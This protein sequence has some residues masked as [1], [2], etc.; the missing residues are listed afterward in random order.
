[1]QLFVR[2]CPSVAGPELNSMKLYIGLIK[3]K[4][5]LKYDKIGLIPFSLSGLRTYLN[6]V[7]KFLKVTKIN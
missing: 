7:Q 4:Y 1:M 2:Y 5:F 6:L 3:M